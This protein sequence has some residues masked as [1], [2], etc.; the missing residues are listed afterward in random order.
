MLHIPGQCS[1]KKAQP[2]KYYSAGTQ[3][4]P[5]WR[6]AV[7]INLFRCT[8]WRDSNLRSLVHKSRALSTRLPCPQ[9]HLV[10]STEILFDSMLLQPGIGVVQ[11]FHGSFNQDPGKIQHMKLSRSTRIRVDSYFHNQGK[12]LNSATLV[13]PIQ[14]H[15]GCFNQNPGKF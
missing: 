5:G 4:A 1:L 15:W 9:T 12:G 2:Y 14:P 11:C 10:I 7:E 3:L 13:S 8:P 6:E